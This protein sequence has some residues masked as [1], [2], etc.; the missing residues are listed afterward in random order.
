MA[1]RWIG[2]SADGKTVTLKHLEDCNIQ[3]PS[4]FTP[5]WTQNH[6]EKILLGVCLDVETTGLN[7]ANDVIIEIA[8]Q[9]FLFNKNTG[10]ILSYARSYTSLQDPGFPLK[11]ETTRLTG[12]TDDMVAGQNIDW[13]QVDQL[14]NESSIVIAH[15]AKFDRPFIEKKSKVSAHKLWACSMKQ[16]DWD[17]K[18]F[19]SAKLELLNIY[20]GFFTDSHRALNDVH[21]LLYILGHTDAQSNQPN[22]HEL[23]TKANRLLC[24]V[25]ASSSPF[26]SKDLLK[27]RGYS[28]DVTN[29]FWAKMIFKDEQIQEIKWLEDS[30]YHGPFRGLT[31]DIT[32]TDNFKA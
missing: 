20:H 19:T 25:I 14:L 32:P 29:R 15:N 17:A 27:A 8:L 4:Y 30:V 31:R 5:E 9:Q 24:H 23:I 11:A 22:L 28:W 12:I 26:E 10:E 21:A 1:F 18:G 7:S 16:V 3:F 2:K 13:S 6:Q